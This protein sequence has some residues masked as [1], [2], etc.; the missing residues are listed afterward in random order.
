MR[1]HIAPK[2]SLGD[3]GSDWFAVEVVDRD[4]YYGSLKLVHVRL[5][6]HALEI[7]DHGLLP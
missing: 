3:M 6:N 4:R 5:G 2:R 7:R 1:W